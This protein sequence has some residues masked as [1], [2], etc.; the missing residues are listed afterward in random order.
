MSTHLVF[1][2]IS[3]V[4]PTPCVAGIGVALQVVVWVAEDHRFWGDLQADSSLLHVLLLKLLPTLQLSCDV[5][6]DLSCLLGF[7]ANCVDVRDLP[8]HSFPFRFAVPSLV[9]D[10]DL[11]PG[12]LVD[13][14][15]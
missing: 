5:C 14:L 6:W 15:G 8:G 13:L 1:D 10:L 12:E 9:N 11:L 3:D 2:C 4:S 7:G